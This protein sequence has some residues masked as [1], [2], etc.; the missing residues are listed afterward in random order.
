MRARG[1]TLIEVLVV[2]VIIGLIAAGTILTI[3]SS[4][5]DSGL[6]TEAER[7]YSL[8]R[9]VREQAELSTREYGL[10]AENGAYEFVAF[11]ARSGLW[12]SVEEDDILR[13]RNL[14]PGLRLRLRV[15]EREVVLR[16]PQGEKEPKPQVMLF[17]NGDIT[18]FEISLERENAG[19]SVLV[20]STDSGELELLPIE[21]P[22][23]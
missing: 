12:R 3:G 13:L 15:E 6:D 4:G 2:V 21:E 9:Y 20:R 8:L 5:R 16:R 17:S 22:E 10:R 14:P 7:L 23:R 19:R 18:D 11:D 1:F